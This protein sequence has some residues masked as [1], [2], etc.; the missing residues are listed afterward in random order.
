MGLS[1]WYNKKWKKDIATTD[2]PN[3][4]KEAIVC[5]SGMMKRQPRGDGP[6]AW[7]TT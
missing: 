7:W 2:G 4:P 6:I 5:A 1:C 3:R